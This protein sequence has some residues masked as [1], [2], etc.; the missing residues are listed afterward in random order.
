[1]HLLQNL[2]N[3]RHLRAFSL[4]ARHSSVKRAAA[5]VFLSQ[6]AVTQAVSKL[7]AEFGETF[8]TRTPTGMYCTD[9]GKVFLHRI[10]RALGTLA[11]VPIEPRGKIRRD[12]DNSPLSHLTSAHLRAMIAV[13]DIGSFDAA[14]E[15]L[16]IS[17]TSLLRTVR[18]LEHIF[19]ARFF[20]RSASGVVLSQ[21]GE[22]FARHAKLAVREIETGI[23]E[24]E[25]LRGNK[26]GRIVVG[27]MPLARVDI[28]PNAIIK[29]LGRFPDLNIRI[30]EGPYSTLMSGLRS[31][32]IDVV[33]GALRSPAPYP[34]V[35]EKVLFHD[36]LAVV[37]RV[38]HPLAKR[39]TISLSDTIGYPWVI[40]S[41]GTPTRDH[42][43]AAFRSRALME[44]KRL[45]EV[46]SNVSLR[47]LLM[48]SDRI[49]MVSSRQVRLEQK[50]GLLEILPI[51]LSDTRRPIG[52]TTR[53]D[54]VPSRAQADLL[55]ELARAGNDA[56][57]P[58]SRL[59]AG[60]KRSRTDI[61]PV[62]G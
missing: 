27:S 60:I 42:F 46:S 6:P 26:I 19:G 47:G 18:S 40:P 54:W 29:L 56:P 41:V 9:F 15:A 30:V 25:H 7:E 5:E 34:D 52:V 58:E 48:E 62:P 39:N 35:E 3:L 13:A 31:G 1:M 28:V 50:A 22:T 49:A 32:E 12:V 24:I 51:D 8:F 23:E 20:L 61:S 57:T 43:H 36:I 4:T 33:V 45:L 16:G 21:D 55:E 59:G 37:V 2:P 11:S 44:P 53:R 14:A 10:D 17:R 38:G